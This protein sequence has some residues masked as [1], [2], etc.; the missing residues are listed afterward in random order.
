L[1]ENIDMPDRP[2]SSW[3]ARHDNGWITLVEEGADGTWSAW[4]LRE[5]SVASGPDYIEMDDE[6]AKAAAEFALRVRSGHA[7][8]SPRCSGW[9]LHTHRPS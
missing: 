3:I 4:A 2:T 5:R 1:N 9:E 6:T 8:C 7:Q